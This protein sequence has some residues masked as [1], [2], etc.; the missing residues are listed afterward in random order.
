MTVYT[1]VNGA[2]NP[3]F[4]I[5][6]FSIDPTAY[7]GQTINVD[8]FDVGDVGGGAAY[9]GLQEPD[10]SWATA[11]SITDLGASL[12]GASPPG[13]GGNVSAAWPGGGCATAVRGNVGLDLGQRRVAGEGAAL[14]ADQIASAYG[15]SGLYQ[16]GD[17]GQGQ[18]IA[19]YELEP[20]DPG[21]IA[22]FQS[23]YGTQASV[24]YVPVDGGAGSGA[25]L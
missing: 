13:G 5:P 24:S 8:L 14:T 7:A 15:F 6:L 12:G 17:Q 19:L 10:G 21:D 22:A 23:C 9:V 20:N 18:T 25:D 1:P 16:A 4:S 11:N 3:Q 2:T